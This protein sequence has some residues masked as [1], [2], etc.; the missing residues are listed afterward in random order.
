[1]AAPPTLVTVP[2]VKFRLD[3]LIGWLDLLGT[4]TVKM[5]L[6]LL[7]LM[8][9]R[10]CGPIKLTGSV[11][12]SWPVERV[13]V[14]LLANAVASKAMLSTPAAALAS[15]TACRSEPAP[16]SAVLRTVNVAGVMRSSSERTHNRRD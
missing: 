8:V 15:S 1:M 11:I 12:E 9:T 3:R 16:A 5:R 6:L 2:L 13:I 7:A 4:S 10:N 14:W